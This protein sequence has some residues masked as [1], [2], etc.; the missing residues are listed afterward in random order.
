MRKM[1]FVI[2]TLGLLGRQK[3]F[4]MLIIPNGGMKSIQKHLKYIW[5]IRYPSSNTLKYIQY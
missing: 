1:P 3:N 5:K 4:L 2:Y